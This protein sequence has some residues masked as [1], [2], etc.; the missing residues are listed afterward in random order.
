[1]PHHSAA[2][3]EVPQGEQTARI[4]V[5][6]VVEDR[7]Y[8]ECVALA[9]GAARGIDVVATARWRDA[10]RLIAQ[11]RPDVLVAEMHAPAS[12]ATV[13][14][15]AGAGRPKVVAIAIGESP[16]E[17]IVCAEAGV[18]GYVTCDE[19]LDDALRAVR[20]VAGGGAHCSGR[21]AAA[22][23]RRLSTLAESATEDDTRRLTSREAE[24]VELID[25]GL[26]NREIATALCIEV[27]TVKN[28]VHNILEK[29]DVRRRS[30]AA[31]LVRGDRRERL[32]RRSR[33]VALQD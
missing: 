7:V 13:R 5:M 2:H 9:L 1:V 4:R 32:S 18:S 10:R 25:A 12:I 19:S 14:H 26:T 22:L 11:S 31:A 24:I 21:V 17:V 33:S 30:D 8:R 27:A 15:V 29:L 20:S 3:G 28:H 6:V 16:E 23:V